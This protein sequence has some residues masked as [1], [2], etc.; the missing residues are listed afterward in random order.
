MAAEASKKLGRQFE[1]VKERLDRE[2]HVAYVK[3]SPGYGSLVKRI[4]R[5]TPS[6]EADHKNRKGG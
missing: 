3:N 4:L 2:P 5:E 6:V 1:A